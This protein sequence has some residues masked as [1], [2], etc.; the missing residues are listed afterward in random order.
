MPWITIQFVVATGSVMEKERDTS[1]YSGKFY[2][3]FF[4]WLMWIF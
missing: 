4:V 2:C 1:R 3:Q